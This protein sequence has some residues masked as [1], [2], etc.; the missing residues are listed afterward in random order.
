MQFD[1]KL[2]LW[3]FEIQRLKPRQ[4]VTNVSEEQTASIRRLDIRRIERI[5]YY[6]KRG[7][8]DH[9]DEV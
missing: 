3:P 8:T 5:A 1:F 9:V 6:G 4:V 7:E 2:I